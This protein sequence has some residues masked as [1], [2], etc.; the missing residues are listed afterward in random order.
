MN[1]NTYSELCIFVM[2]RNIKMALLLKPF[3][4]Y[5]SFVKFSHT[6]FALPFALI[7]FFLGLQNMANS[8]DYRILILVILCM[9]FARSAA[10]GFNRL[11]D[12]EIDKKNPRTAKREIP[13]GKIS[14]KSA[15]IF[16]I[17]SSL[18]FIATTWFINNICFF[19]SPV[20]LVIILGYSYTKRFTS[21]SHYMLGLGLSLSPI[22]AYLAVTGKFNL[23]PLL[24]SIIVF[25]WVA[26]FDII[27]ALQDV[28]FD[29]EQN[30]KSIPSRFGINRA[31]IISVLSH[32]ISAVVLVY[33]GILGKSGLLFWVGVLIFLFLLVYQHLIVKPGKLERINQAFALTN[34]L[35]GVSLS[36]F[37]IADVFIWVKIF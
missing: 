20:A 11:A 24:Y 16:V 1:N 37:Y 23:V 10:M 12:R 13:S 21:L 33:A 9:L 28:D 35:A 32:S 6:I 27:Y 5:L 18:C 15:F 25:F 26:G 31:L 14:P 34:G 7:G 17:I 36:L 22:G 8:F 3:R 4:N 29:R 30:L 2:F 19:L